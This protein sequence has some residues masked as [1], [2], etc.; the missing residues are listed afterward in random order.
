M[1]STS[2]KLS[3]NDEGVASG[4]HS[5]VTENKTFGCSYITGYIVILLAIKKT[6]NGGL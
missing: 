5:I 6:N 3:P 2:A 1:I 4:R